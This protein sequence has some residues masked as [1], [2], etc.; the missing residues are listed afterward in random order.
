MEAESDVE[1]T[2]FSSELVEVCPLSQAYVRRL[3]ADEYAFLERESFASICRQNHLLR[4]IGKESS[5][6][7][8]GSSE[9]QELE[10][11]PRPYFCPYYW[12]ERARQLIRASEEEDP[13][14]RNLLNRQS[15]LLEQLEDER[16]C[17]VDRGDGSKEEYECV[18]AS[19]EA[20][21]RAGCVHGRPERGLS[22]PH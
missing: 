1:A 9:Q 4:L 6:H 3:Y 17:I 5:M 7:L 16:L 10:G 22:R 20:W 15:R 12:T 19:A 8:G 18:P 21:F 11:H 2:P 13:K 14:L